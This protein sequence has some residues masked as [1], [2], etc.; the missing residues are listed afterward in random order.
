VCGLRSRPFRGPVLAAPG[1]EADLS[2]T[3]SAYAPGVKLGHDITFVLRSMNA[4]PDAAT[5]V[6]VELVLEPDLTIRRRCAWWDMQRGRQR[7]RLQPRLAGG[8]R[9][10]LGHGPRH[11]HGDGGRRATGA[12]ESDTTDSVPTNNTVM[13]TQ[14]VGPA[15]RTC[16]LWGHSRR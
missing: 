16:D 8:G 1:D 12:V 14:R 13:F 7:R 2:I 3:G 4:G 5:N 9:G 6:A 15:S 11:D 10:L